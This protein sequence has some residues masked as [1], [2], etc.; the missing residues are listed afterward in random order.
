[1]LQ[2]RAMMIHLDAGTQ[3]KA[4]MRAWSKEA[5]ELACFVWDTFNSTVRDCKGSKCLHSRSSRKSKPR[6]SMVS[7][8][9]HERER[10]R[11]MPKGV[12]KAHVRSCSRSQSMDIVLMPRGRG[13]RMQ[14]A[15]K[16]TTAGERPCATKCVPKSREEALVSAPPVEQPELPKRLQCAGIQAQREALRGCKRTRALPTDATSQPDGD[17]LQAVD[18][19]FAQGQRQLT[20][21]NHSG[22]PLYRCYSTACTLGVIRPGFL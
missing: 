6:E 7:E 11:G 5:D 4:M 15:M 13:R 19:A 12:Q 8:D 21:G 17:R 18:G 10:I 14:T 22:V 9:I 16:R 1:M 20:S 3:K 2:H